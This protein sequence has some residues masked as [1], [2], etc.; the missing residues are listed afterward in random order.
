[1]VRREDFLVAG[2]FRYMYREDADFAK[3]VARLRP[4][5]MQFVMDAVIGTPARRSLFWD[6]REHTPR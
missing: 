6:W 3:R 1:M 2:G 4:G 5:G